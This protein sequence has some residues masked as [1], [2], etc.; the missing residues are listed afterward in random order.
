M[1]G[2][3]G[4]L[5][6]FL[7]GYSGLRWQAN[8][9]ALA[10][11]LTHQLTGVVL[12]NLSWRGRVFTVSVGQRTTT[13]T[14][15]SGAS[16]PV[17]T[18]RGTLVL[19]AGQ[20]LQI[21]TARPDLRATRDVVRCR[22]ARASNAEP[23]AP[24]LAAVDGSS[25]TDWQAARLPATITVPLGS[26][27]R[28]ISRVTV[29]WG[30]LWPGVKKANV[31][32]APGP[33]KTLRASSYTV[34][35]SLNG[36]NWRTVASVTGVTTRITDVLRLSPVR[37]RYIRLRLTKGGLKPIKKTKTNKNPPPTTP[38]VMELTVRR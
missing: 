16:M 15:Q 20:P 34:Q 21:P 30:R 27:P 37:A 4:F 18:P 28:R 3:G 32:P 5:Q 19:T 11:S 13:V 23:G 25:A 36:K 22:P 14:L 26:A 24:A 31:P 38:M 10:P 2:I 6:E 35:A 29:V 12:H 7:Y 9:V 33:V 17:S 1:T 8:D